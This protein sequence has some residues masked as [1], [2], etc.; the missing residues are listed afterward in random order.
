MN[1]SIQ[2][3][4]KNENK[5]YTRT[6]DKGETSLRKGIRV[7]KSDERVETYGTV[8][9]LNSCLGI[10]ITQISLLQFCKSGTAQL[11][12][13]AKHDWQYVKNKLLH[14]LMNIQNDLF[15]IG[16]TL[17]NPENPKLP[18]LKNRVVVFEQFID[19]M[20]AVLPELHNFI[21]PGGSITGAQLHLARTI[22]RRAERHV[23]GLSQTQVID[24]YIRMYLN[25][26]SDLLFTMAR[27]VNYW[28]NKPETLW[29]K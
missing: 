7:L 22:C 16:S 21:L 20:T 14:E 4:V 11:R 25:R 17:A 1:K 28:E 18:E 24:D 26:L 12:K 19:E 23:V 9:E 8:D 6:G 3:T 29:K 2:N 10:V 15:L 13:G 5:I 27:Y